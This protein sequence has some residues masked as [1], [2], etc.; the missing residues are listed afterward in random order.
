MRTENEKKLTLSAMF[1]AMGIVLP[2]LFGQI[3][4]IGSMLLPMHIP[5]FLCA[6]LCG[7]QYSL[8]MAFVLPI[9]RSLLF[10]RPNFYPEAIAIA[11][12][13]ATYALITGLLYNHTKRCGTGVVYR[14]LAVAMVG[15]RIVRCGVQL[16]LLTLNGMPF[17]FGGFLVGTILAGI[18]GI[19]LQ[20]IMI[21][22]VML[23]LER[24][25]KLFVKE[26]QNQK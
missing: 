2:F 9:L 23:I 15:G 1:L 14:C 19:L 21:P 6:F 11:F 25:D 26:Q 17:L 18:P 3:P 24:N 16:L 7:W 12:E 13:L 4:Q 22:A 10:G 8:P 20:L 5:V